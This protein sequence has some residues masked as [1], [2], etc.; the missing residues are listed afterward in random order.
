MISNHNHGSEVEMS[1]RLVKGTIKPDLYYF[2]L[3]H[4][5]KHVENLNMLNADPTCWHP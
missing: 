2:R 3:S 1:T 5:I 4:K